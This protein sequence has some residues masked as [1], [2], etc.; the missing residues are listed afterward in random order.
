MMDVVL[1]HDQ[2]KK[3]EVHLMECIVEVEMEVASCHNFDSCDLETGFERELK[4]SLVDKSQWM[5]QWAF[6]VEC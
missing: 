2:V 4:Y 3:L 1:D 6:V 5:Y